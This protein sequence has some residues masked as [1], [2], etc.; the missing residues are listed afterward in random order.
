MEG[1]L[2]RTLEDRLVENLRDG[3]EHDLVELLLADQDAVPAD[4]GPALVVEVA[5][6]ESAALAGALVV[7]G[8]G[9]ERAA[10]R[11][12]PGDAAQQVLLLVRAVGRAAAEGV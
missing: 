5:A 6:V 4:L 9:H 11:R 8:E 7:A 10:A 2:D 3:V 12:A 1:L